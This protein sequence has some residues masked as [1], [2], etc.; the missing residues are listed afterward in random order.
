MK[1]YSL[2]YGKGTIPFTPPSGRE[3]QLIEPK[4]HQ[5]PEDLR[6]VVDHALNHPVNSPSL[7]ELS[8][9]AR[10][11]LIITDD[12]TR[13]MPSK[14]TIP[15]ILNAF[16]RPA[17]EYDITILIATGL[18]RKMTPDEII[19]QFGRETAENYKIVN[20]VATDESQLA[21]YGKMKSGNELWLNRLVLESDLVISEGFIEAHFFAGFSGGRKSILPGVAGAQTIM[22]NHCPANIADVRSFG[23]SLDGNPIHAE[24]VEAAKKARLGFIL[25]VALNR[26]KKIIGAFAGNPVDAHLKGCEFVKEA[27]S[28]NVHLTDIVVTSNN[29]YPLDRNLYQV[30]KGIDVASGVVPRGGVIIMAAQCLDG[31]GHKCFKELM[32]SGSSV[33][34]LNAKLS[35]PPNEIDKWQAQILARAL[36]KCTII[37]VNDTMKKE[38]VESMFFIYAA[39][40]DE[41]LETALR[42]KGKDAGIS[43]I[44]EGPV[45]IPVVGQ[46]GQVHA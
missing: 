30:V 17:S 40:M 23:A 21:F 5:A 24:C 45:V 32:Q 43:V 42:I 25:N 29:G 8:K 22:G 41:A 46:G 19:E 35:A 33:A 34:E 20:H 27:M 18:H 16:Y 9:D 28:V 11:I 44:P 2:Q 14:I 1:E 7:K 12:N 13:P 3:V 37:L 15:A 6:A 38:E 31:V 10:S 4:A 26:E 39:N 36:L